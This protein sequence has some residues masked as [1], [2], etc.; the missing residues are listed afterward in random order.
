[1]SGRHNPILGYLV[2]W[3]HQCMAVHTPNPFYYMQILQVFTHGFF[4]TI[5]THLVCIF[6]KR[7]LAVWIVAVCAANINS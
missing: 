7:L 6:E 4:V 3:Y 1:M 5:Q 2:R